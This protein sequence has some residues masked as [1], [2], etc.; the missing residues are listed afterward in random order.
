MM[1]IGSGNPIIAWQMPIVGVIN[2]IFIFWL[3]ES[4]ITVLPRLV[5]LSFQLLNNLMLIG[6]LKT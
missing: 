5:L 2:I 3:I 4:M 6:N 1:L